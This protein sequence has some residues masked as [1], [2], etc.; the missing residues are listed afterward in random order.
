MGREL[1]DPR[2]SAL[3]SVMPR[4]PSDDAVTGITTA[5]FVAVAG[6]APWAVG[7][8]IYQHPEG[9]QSAAGRY[10]LLLAQAIVL[11]TAV[12][13]G[14]GVVRSRVH[15]GRVPAAEAARA[16]PGRSL[17][18]DST[19]AGDDLLADGDLDARAAALLRRVQDAV[20]A[21]ISAQ[22]CRDGLLDEPAT[23]AALAAQHSE[24]ADALRE[25]ARLRAERSWLAE[26]SPGSPAAELLEQHRQ[27]AQAARSPSPP[28]SR[29][30]SATR[31]RSIRPTPSTA[32]GVSTRPSPSSPAPTWTCSPAPPPTSTA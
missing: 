4:V 18:A 8:L 7:V 23:T 25:Q 27:A 15:G 32:T 22:I 1:V 26:P 9:W 29:R 10:A 21:V 30:L 16:S 2:R 6:A 3:E 12:V 11:V 31:P 14:T 24:I 20:S 13:V 28:G 19:L 5:L 17:A